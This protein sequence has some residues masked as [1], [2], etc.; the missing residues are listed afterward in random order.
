M[1]IYCIN[2]NDRPE[3]LARTREELAKQ[4][5]NA[6]RVSAIIN[7]PGWVGCR[8]SHLK[9][10]ERHAKNSAFMIIED[11]IAFLNDYEPWV[12][13]AM[14][15]LP[16][17]WDML[18]LSASPKTPQERYSNNLF[19]LRGA[20]CAHAIIYHPREGGAVEYILSH[21]EDIKKI[22]RYYA[23]TVQLLFNC[24]ITAPIICTQWQHSSDT[25]QRTDSSTI[26]KNYI[27]YC[28]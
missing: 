1:I 24:Y 2:R 26:Y 10:I 21:R 3:R 23:D 14:S 13:M 28:K 5:L 4:S 18:Y 12:T 15:Q 19:R 20:V 17:D 22:D 25:C 6:H 11:D 8:E 27:Q 7:T 9:V 16:S